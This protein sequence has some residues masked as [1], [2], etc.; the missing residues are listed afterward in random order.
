MGQATSSGTEFKRSTVQT[1]TEVSSSTEAVEDED[2]CVGVGSFVLCLFAS[3][4]VVSFSFPDSLFSPSEGDATT[5]PTPAAAHTAGEGE[6]EDTNGEDETRHDND[7]GD[8]DGSTASLLFGVMMVGWGSFCCAA[9]EVAIIGECTRR[10]GE[11]RTR[12]G[13]TGGGRTTARGEASLG[14]VLLDRFVRVGV[15][16][17]GDG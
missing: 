17:L 13:G 9:T 15:L 6:E 16:V 10:R 2:V 12:S 1:P 7:R 14:G 5:K 11:E 8:D 4:L 3:S